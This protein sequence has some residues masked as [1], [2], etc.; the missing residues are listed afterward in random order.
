MHSAIAGLQL[1]TGDAS[2]RRRLIEGLHQHAAIHIGADRES[3]Q[4]QDGWRYIQQGRTVDALVLLYMCPFHAENPERTV[5]NGWTR[6]LCGDAAW[7][8]VIGMKAVI[9][10]Q[11][12]GCL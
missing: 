12:H 9:G 4:S 1:P 2:N 6:R 3:K 5:L 8:Q 11:H 7:A 10:N